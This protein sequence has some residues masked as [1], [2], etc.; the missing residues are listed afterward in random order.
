[1]TARRHTPVIAL[2]AT[3]AT[4]RRAVPLLALLGVRARVVSWHRPAPSFVGTPDALLVTEPSLLPGLP[5]IPTAVW[6]PDGAVAPAPGCTRLV[7]A[8]D[9]RAAVAPDAVVVPEHG[10]EVGAWPVLPPLVRARWRARL[11]LPAS[12][13]LAVDARQRTADATT[14]LALASAAVVA[15]R[16]VPLALALGTPVVTDPDTAARLGLAVGVE[17]EVAEDPRDADR[18]AARLA[19]SDE[20]TARLSRL[21]RRAAEDRFDLGRAAAALRH[22]LGVDPA[23]GSGPADPADLLVARLAELGTPTT[24]TVVGHAAAC[25]ADLP[26]LTGASR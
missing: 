4:A 25:V 14:A 11:D 15:P 21:G 10:I 9:H 23:T 26:R 18:L 12:L 22:R 19:A 20:R 16:H 17:V 1:M 3:P 13:V 24:A 7:P 8:A 6:D 2:V 5:D